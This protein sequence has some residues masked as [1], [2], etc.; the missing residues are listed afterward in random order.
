MSW[1]IEYGFGLEIVFLIINAPT[2][3]SKLLSF[4][5]ANAGSI[6]INDDIISLFRLAIATAMIGLA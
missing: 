4:M 1:D 2:I 5:I 6:F 3:E